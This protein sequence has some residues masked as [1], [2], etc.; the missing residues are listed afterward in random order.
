LTDSE[1]K[2]KRRSSDMVFC[3]FATDIIVLPEGVVSVGEETCTD[4][5]SGEQIEPWFMAQFRRTEHTNIRQKKHVDLKQSVVIL[6][7]LCACVW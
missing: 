2:R 6:R 3:L 1:E 4:I 7:L 5:Q